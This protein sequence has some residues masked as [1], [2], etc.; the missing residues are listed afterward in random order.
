MRTIGT[1]GASVTIARHDVGS[2]RGLV[3]AKSWHDRRSVSLAADL[4]AGHLDGALAA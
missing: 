1:A 2:W 3:Q 4:D